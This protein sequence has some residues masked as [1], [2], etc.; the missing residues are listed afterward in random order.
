MKGRGERCTRRF[1][2]ALRR[3]VSLFGR[4]GPAWRGRWQRENSF[5]KDAAAAA[6]A[7]TA[8]RINILPWAWRTDAP[9]IALWHNQISVLFGGLFL[10]PYQM[11]ILF[12]SLLFSSLSF[13][14][15]FI[16]ITLVV[17]FHTYN[18][19]IHI[20]CIY[21]VI[22][23]FGCVYEMIVNNAV[24]PRLVALYRSR[25]SFLSSLK[26]IGD[27]RTW[28]RSISARPVFCCVVRPHPLIGINWSKVDGHVWIKSYFGRP[29]VIVLLHF[30]Y[31]LITRFLF[32]LSCK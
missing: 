17:V 1:V 29:P 24:W 19:S 16:I 7:M 12:L 4:E 8:E 30:H 21:L 3:V 26:I 18:T 23:L 27:P 14:S 5:C 6:N 15:L 2:L 22:H 13:L 32:A 25:L 11:I 20:I 31:F 10:V 9:Y 28:F